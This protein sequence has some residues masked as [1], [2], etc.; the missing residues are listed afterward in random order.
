MTARE[1]AQKFGD[2]KRRQAL[3]CRDDALP[4]KDIRAPRLCFAKKRN[5]Q[6]GRVV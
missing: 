5:A 3:I 4:P 1:S 2:K 6:R